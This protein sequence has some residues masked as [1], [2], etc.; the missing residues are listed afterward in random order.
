M[1]WLEKKIVGIKIL[2]LGGFFLFRS[3]FFGNNF[4]ELGSFGGFKKIC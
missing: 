3:N 1:G 4:F 2:K